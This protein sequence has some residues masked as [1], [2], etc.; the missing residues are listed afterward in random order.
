MFGL[1]TS[2]GVHGNQGDLHFPYRHAGLMS[3]V[4]LVMNPVAGEAENRVRGSVPR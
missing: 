4:V 2:S 1:T 3:G